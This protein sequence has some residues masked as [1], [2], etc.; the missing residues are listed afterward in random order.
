MLTGL[1]SIPLHRL[2]EYYGAPEWPLHIIV[3]NGVQKLDLHPPSARMSVQFDLSAAHLSRWLVHTGLN[4]TCSYTQ[5]EQNWDRA[6]SY[7]QT[8]IIDRLLSADYGSWQDITT[9][10]HR[11][12]GVAF[13]LRG[14][15]G[16]KT[17]VLYVPQNINDLTKIC[18]W[19]P[20]LEASNL[21]ARSDAT[22][23][24]LVPPLVDYFYLLQCL[25]PGSLIITGVSTEQ[26]ALPLIQWITNRHQELKHIFGDAGYRVLYAS[27]MNNGKRGFFI[28]KPAPTQMKK[29]KSKSRKSS[30]TGMGSSRRS[31]DG[32][33]YDY[34]TGYDWTACSKDHCGWCGHCEY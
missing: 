26:V 27:A 8:E 28:P 1:I 16:A 7:I 31:D 9:A 3:Q 2:K 20:R 23:V 11:K 21:I 29:K 22:L 19:T 18:L 15:Q 10:S 4:Q 33:G 25:L 34:G 5:R 30:R 17:S 32:T 12:D 24:T 6:R 14:L 13:V